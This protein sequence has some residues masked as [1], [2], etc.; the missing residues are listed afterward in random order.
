M[1]KADTE[2]AVLPPPPL[3]PPGPYPPNFGLAG[4]SQI[5]V[6]TYLPGQM[7]QAP[8]PSFDIGALLGGIN[9]FGRGI[10]EQ[11]ALGGPQ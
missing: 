6:P 4:P 7:T 11:G 8:Q 9:D 2:A 10:I 1:A 5:P 3:V